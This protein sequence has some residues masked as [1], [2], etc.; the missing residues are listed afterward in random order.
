[1]IYN[2]VL[3]AIGQTPIIRLNRLNDRDSAE[4]LVKYEGLS[5]Y[6]VRI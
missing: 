2:N 3:E 1:M 5:L 6:P 4:A